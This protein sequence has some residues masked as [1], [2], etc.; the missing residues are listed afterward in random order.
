MRPIRLVVLMTIL[1]STALTQRL[2]AQD[3]DFDALLDE[4]SFEVD[5]PAA[6]PMEEPAPSPAPVEEPSFDELFGMEGEDINTDQAPVEMMV[7]EPSPVAAEEDFSLDDLLAEDESEIPPPVELQPEVE[8]QPTTEMEEL[9]GMEEASAE[10]S[11]AGD[12]LFA[13]P[14]ESVA[15]E[16]QK[17]L[18]RAEPA[19]VAMQ[20]PLVESPVEL[21]GAALLA[22]QEEVRRQALEVQA[23]KNYEDGIAAL[24]AGKYEQAVKLLEAARREIPARPANEATR[25]KLRFSL[26]DAYYSL[27]EQLIDSDLALA[28]RNIELA[29]QTLPESRRVQALDKKISVQE[30]KA[31]ERAKLP[32][33]V[34][35]Q[36]K[37]ADKYERIDLLLREGREL[38]DSREYNDAE[39]IFESVLVLDEYNV[40]AMRYLRRIEEQRYA[41][42]TRERDATAEGMMAMVRDTWN[43]PIRSDVVVPTPGEP[44]TQ[45]EAL[46]AQQKLQGKMEDIV[47]PFIEFRQANITDVVTFLV[48]A[49]VAGDPEGVGVNIILKLGGAEGAAPAPAPAAPA[50]SGFDDFGFGGD[51]GSFDEPAPA[52][53]PVSTGV[54][55]ITLN[56][57]RINLLD[58]IKYIT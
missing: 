38:Y 3:M 51:F 22:Q 48:D 54:P 26:G 40:D 39:K 13:A 19:P 29:K 24:S 27:A 31:A 15:V 32:V 5:E 34:G 14:D 46:T 2:A 50:S 45:I 37:Y 1:L 21:T 17:D 16:P 43:P 18:Y 44:Q 6:P 49:S 55:A 7:E 33:P 42:K 30:V 10:P 8:V 56:L 58:A 53:A 20:Q 12:E 25:E 23:N 52:P 11:V 41:K 28:R 47:I 57:R 36:P 9:F 4:L 35:D